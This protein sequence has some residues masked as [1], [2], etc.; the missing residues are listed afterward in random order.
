MRLLMAGESFAVV[1]DAIAGALPPEEAAPT[2][3]AWLARW[4]EDGV[5]AQPVV[6]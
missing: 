1:C 6:L 3:V 4:I 2:A 5:L